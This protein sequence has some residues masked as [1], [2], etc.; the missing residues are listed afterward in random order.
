MTTP[1]EPDVQEMAD[2]QADPFLIA[3]P[4]S[5]LA[6][7]QE[8]LAVRDD[9]EVLSV[10]PVA[11]PPERIVAR[12]PSTAAVELRKEFEGQ[13]VIEADRPLSPFS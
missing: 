8:R 10:S 13:V 4:S 12:L 1:D 5:V 3:G 6:T 2:G 9:A 7:I 11:G